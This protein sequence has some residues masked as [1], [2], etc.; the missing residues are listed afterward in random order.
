VSDSL[1]NEEA[2]SKYVLTSSKA[3]TTLFENELYGHFL[4]VLYS[5]ID[6]VGL[7]NAPPDVVSATSGTFKPWVEQFLIPHVQENVSPTDLWAARCA[8]LHTYSTVSDLS[9]SGRARQLQ[10]YHG[11]ASKPELS[12]FIE[13]TNRMHNGAHVAVHLGKLGA[14]FAL[15]LIDFVPVLIERCKSCPATSRRLRDVMQVYPA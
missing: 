1:A 8:V 12:R 11:D 3:A 13:I 6:T 10:Y 9:R 4:I 14:S 5:T 7:L 15:A 2:I